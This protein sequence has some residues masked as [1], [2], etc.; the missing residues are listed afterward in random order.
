[1]RAKS[2]FSA[3]LIAGFFAAPIASAQDADTTVDAQSQDDAMREMARKAQ[4][5]LGSV[6][7]LMTDNTIAMNGGPDDDTSYSFQIQPVY[8]I[9][10]PT[11]F[12]MIARG[13]LPVIGLE[14]G[15]VW[16]P[17]G[18]EP[19][20]DK[21][22]RWGLGDTVLQFFL[23]PKG[24]G[25]WKWGA[26]PQ[27]SLPT[28]TGD[29]QAGPG[30]GAGLAGV[31]FGS[32]GNWAI[33]GIAMQHW[34]EE[35]YSVGTLQIIGLYNF[36][37]LPGTYLGY[38]NSITYNW[39]GSSGDKLTLPL[40]ATVGRTLLLKSG[41]GLDLNLGAYAMAEKPQDAPSWQLKFGISYYFN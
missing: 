37:S 6:R 11:G 2:H 5:P 9:E 28:H 22:S 14:P 8:A 32:V 30:W 23:S 29:R 27:V 21:D 39:E 3:G 4:D 34:G 36:D 25:N 20:P 17:I 12:N 1:M 10:N 31:I 35:R 26:G 15:V 41:D 16:P 33:G 18:P 24:G 19:T 38:N 40:G 13:I 7:A